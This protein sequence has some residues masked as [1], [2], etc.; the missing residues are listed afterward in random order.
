MN[1]NEKKKGYQPGYPE[2]FFATHA[3]SPNA[4]PRRL[5]KARR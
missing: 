1:Q 2:I 3:P 5:K 4:F